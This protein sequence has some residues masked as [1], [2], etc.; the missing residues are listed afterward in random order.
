MILWGNLCGL[1]AEEEVPAEN[2]S[3]PAA[4]E[5]ATQEGKLPNELSLFNAAV[6][7]YNDNL[8]ERAKDEFAQFCINYPNS[9]NLIDATVYQG[10]ALYRMGK[11]V[12]SLNFFRPLISETNNAAL[13]AGKDRY[14]YWS[15]LSSFKLQDFPG[16]ITALSRLVSEYPKSSLIPNALYYTGNSWQKLGNTK[17]AIELFNTPDGIFQTLSQQ[18]PNNTYIIQSWLLLAEMYLMQNSF[19][20]VQEILLKIAEH[21]LPPELQWRQLYLQTQLSMAQQDLNGAGV[22]VTNLLKLTTD[23]GL[24]NLEYQALAL[25]GDLLRQENRIDDAVKV[26]EKNVSNT[27]IPRKDRW[28]ALM[29]IVKIDIELG[30]RDAAIN[31]LESFHTESKGD[32]YNDEILV[33]LGN[34]YLQNYYQNIPYIRMIEPGMGIGNPAMQKAYQHYTNLMST[35][36]NS[37]FLSKA[38]LN[39]GLCYWELGFPKNSIDSFSKAVASI[40]IS[41]DNAFARIKLAEVQF[42][43]KDFQGTLQ[44]IGAYLEIYA[45]APGLPAEFLEQAY[46]L[47]LITAVELQNEDLARRAMASILEKYP[48]GYFT[49]R[50]LL[51]LGNYLC[52]IGKTAEGRDLFQECLT[53]FP[54]SELNREA[55]RS[56]ARSWLYERKYDEAIKLYENWLTSNPESSLF[57]SQTEFELAWCY[58]QSGED[59]KALKGFSDF[60]NKYPSAAEVV[61]AKKWIA[62]H[63]FNNKQFSLAEES[64]QQIFESDNLVYPTNSF[65]LEARLMAARSAFARGS[66]R[67]AGEHLRI[68][69]NLLLIPPAKQVEMLDEAFILLG[70]SL[71]EESAF[72]ANPKDRLDRYAKAINAY[73]RVSNESSFRAVA[74]GRIANCHFQLAGNET[75]DD[76]RIKLAIQFYKEAMNHPKAAAVTR[77]HAELGLAALYYQQSMNPKLESTVRTQDL[78]LALDHYLNVYQGKNLLPGEFDAFCTQKAG[79]EAAR[80]LEEQGRWK[81]ALGI[82]R[83]LFDLI[84]PLRPLLREKIRYVSSR[85]PSQNKD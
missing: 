53:L 84:E 22:C 16:A 3:S 18:M 78:A 9:T 83:R 41:E 39:L 73:S 54:N 42:Y 12:E 23:A 64:Y 52:N 19:E 47:Q 63:Y 61:L 72:S 43:E 58:A 68:L 5:K 70:D 56:L 80:I 24:L 4:D 76:R 1:Y 77:L 60:V 82:Y 35:F 21:N 20:K 6:I 74:L 71:T 65:S 66:Y 85:I 55:L 29:N 46:H 45:D 51:Y 50:D 33:T 81:E 48:K 10:I 13:S 2:I 62:D 75:V 59:E 44:T 31:L 38:C 15:G 37:P 27:L 40:P 57:Y 26:Y 11:F 67:D 7:S 34:L 30:K 69:I 49:E 36:T 14:L 25:Q 32:P 28:N 79:M 8:F 17:K